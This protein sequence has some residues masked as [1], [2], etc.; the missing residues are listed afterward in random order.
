MKNVIS[1]QVACTQTHSF[2]FF[3]YLIIALKLGL[4]ISLVNN[5]TRTNIFRSFVLYCV[6]W[7]LYIFR[8]LF[9]HINIVSIELTIAEFGSAIIMSAESSEERPYPCEF[10]QMRFKDALSHKR[11]TNV[12][13]THEE[14]HVCEHCAAVFY[15]KHKLDVHLASK[16]GVNDQ[17]KCGK[18]RRFLMSEWTL[19]KHKRKCSTVLCPVCGKEFMTNW[20]LQNHVNGHLNNLCHICNECGKDFMT[21]SH[22][23]RAHRNCSPR[24]MVI[25]TTYA[26]FVMNVEKTFY[27]VTH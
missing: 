27:T 10:C 21:K 1:A 16:H 11:H 4:S 19:I 9:G 2:A 6:D 23:S 14:T 26:T 25:S 8:Y 22:I 20:K 13:H 12:K 15:T 24:K 3:S 5:C 7:L 18:C 17:F